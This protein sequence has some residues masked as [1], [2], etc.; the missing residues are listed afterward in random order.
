MRDPNIVILAG[1]IASRMRK[2]NAPALDASFRLEA[3][4][5]PKAMIGLGPRKRPFLDYLLHN[6]ARAGYRDVVLVVGDRDESIRATYD[7]EGKGNRFPE[8]TFSFV[9]QPIPPGR[10]KPLG[11][12]DALHRVLVTRPDWRGLRF[13]V[14]NS[15]NLYSVGALR[16]LLAEDHSNATIDYDLQALRF[17]PER[18]Q[19][20]ALLRKDDAGFLQDIIEKPTA[21]QIKH[22]NSVWGRIGVSMNIF[23]LSYDHILPYLERVPLHPT[24]QEKELPNAVRLLVQDNPKAMFVVPLSEHVID[25]TSQSDIAEVQEFLLREYPDF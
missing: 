21:E 11:T 15:D 14:C 10:N 25:L 17:A 3:M 24:R 6:V 7:R 22:L 19:Q 16:T 18:I 2:A 20:F 23:R 9:A 8:L 1:G 13:T 5:K 12:A 4:Q